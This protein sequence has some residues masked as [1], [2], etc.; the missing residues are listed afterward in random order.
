MLKRT[1]T[2]ALVLFVTTLS[3]ASAGAEDPCEAN[4]T[5]VCREAATAS[6]IA[7]ATTF[8]ELAASPTLHRGHSTILRLY[9]AVL[10]RTP[11][12]GGARFW[13]ESY[14]SGEWP[15]RRIAGFFQVS[16]EFVETYGSLNSA[17]FTTLIYT[18]VLGRAPDQGGFDYWK[19]QLDDGMER[20]EMILLISNA[21]EFITRR[22]L[23]SDARPDTGPGPIPGTEPPTG[24]G[25]DGVYANCTAV[26][27][28]IGRPITRDDPGYEPKL[29]RDNDGIGCEI[30]P[31]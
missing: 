1:I 9:W 22:P 21:P 10:A 25:A 31:R 8:D 27:E 17:D 15:A 20:S 11:D 3:S 7:D 28:A 16:D 23:P 6:S 26:W 24:G 30:D 19:G 12:V 13:I 18:N 2:L 14:D 29:D 4:Q 5:E